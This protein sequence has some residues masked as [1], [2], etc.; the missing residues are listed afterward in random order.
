MHKP[1]LLRSPLLRSSFFGVISIIF[2]P[3]FSGQGATTV[4]TTLP[5][6][7]HIVIVMEEN[8]AYSQVIG[9]SSAPYI[10]AL[11]Q[12]GALFTN[13]SAISHPSQPNYVA[14]F[15]G[16]TQ[17][18]T[19]DSC[20]QTFAGPDLGGQ[21][22]TA[23]FSFTGYSEDLPSAGSTVCTAGG[24]VFTPA[25]ARKHAPWTDFTDV[26]ASSNQP[27]TSFP[28]DY[29]T[30]PTVSFVIPNQQDDMHS[31][32]IQQ[33]DSWLQ[34]NIDSY[35]Q[36]AQTHNSLLIVTW[37]EDDSSSGNHIAT[38]FS[39]ANV[40]PGQYT[41]AINHYTVLRTLQDM[42]GLTPINN[43][44]NENPIMDVWN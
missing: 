3:F 6:P 38:I 31:G 24:T 21:L 13:S 17:G 7:D 44:V 35:A 20:P 43:S 29:T 42:Y 18:L 23:G 11:A 25:Y 40:K 8:H 26:P 9:S 39:G 19:D 34:T 28:S 14:L 4:T 33:A 15:S 36:W 16:S 41:E 37:D 22:L 12:Q 32:S 1:G 30:L 2:L 10:N 5:K 27:F